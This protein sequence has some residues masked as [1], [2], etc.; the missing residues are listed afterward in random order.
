MEHIPFEDFVAQIEE[1]NTIVSRTG[2]EYEIES[3]ADGVVTILNPDVEVN[4]RRRIKLD[5]LY[6]AHL[7]LDFGQLSTSKVRP[8]VKTGAAE[9][10]ALL[11]TVF[12]YKALNDA[13][14]EAIRSMSIDDK[15]FIMASMPFTIGLHANFGHEGLARM[16]YAL[17]LIS[18]GKC[19]DKD[20]DELQNSI[21]EYVSQNPRKVLERLPLVDLEVLKAFKMSDSKIYADTP[22]PLMLV[23]SGLVSSLRCDTN[24]DVDMLC[25]NKE[26]MEAVR[27]YIDEAIA[28]KKATKYPIIEQAFRGI[29]NIYGAIDADKALDIL[30]ETLPQMDK[31]I[32][33]KSIREF[34][35]DSMLVRFCSDVESKG[36]ILVWIDEFDASLA[37]YNP[38]KISMYRPKNAAVFLAFGNYP[39]LIPYEK[40][41]K[42]LYGFLTKRFGAL[43]ASRLYTIVFYNLQ[44]SDPS[45]N[46]SVLLDLI[47]TV[48]HRSK[49]KK[50]Y[51]N[52]VLKICTSG[53][54]SFPRVFLKGHSPKDLNGK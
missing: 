2:K 41:Q 52:N 6:Q 1:Y 49:N 11:M 24:D 17:G 42:K 9:A 44:E 32:T 7:A 37:S 21:L 18:L 35:K 25:V 22:L 43:E 26:F 27:P 34:W 46:K 33:S 31:G 45:S 51:T 30:T 50:D 48:E 38:P 40:D 53:V 54:N 39:Y 36:R 13:M 8:Y 15:L 47:E 19:M 14:G 4:C 5:D 10:T 12:G 29:L 20:D 28:A 23:D 16:A 3:I